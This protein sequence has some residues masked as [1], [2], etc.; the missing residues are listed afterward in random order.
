MRVVVASETSTTQAACSTNLE[1]AFD[2][3]DGQ[4][5]DIHELQHHLGRCFCSSKNKI[6]SGKNHAFFTTP[7]YDSPG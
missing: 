2:V 3:G 7:N 4:A 6:V 5:L 1:V